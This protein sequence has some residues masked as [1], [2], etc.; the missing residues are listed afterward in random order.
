[1]RDSCTRKLSHS[2]TALHVHLLL[3]LMLWH[4]SLSNVAI[5]LITGGCRCRQVVPESSVSLSGTDGRG[6]G[7]GGGVGAWRG[8]LH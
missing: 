1:M 7:G 3:M 8:V 5:P 4:E 2:D 6:F